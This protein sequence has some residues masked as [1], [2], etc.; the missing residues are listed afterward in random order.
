MKPRCVLIVGCGIAGQVL[1]C[2]L[3][4]RGMKMIAAKRAIERMVEQGEAVAAVPTVEPGLGLANELRAAGVE[5]TRIAAERVDIAA[6]RTRLGM[7]QEEFALRYN[8]KLRALQNWEQGRE[9]DAVVWSYLQAIARNP[10]DVA[11]AQEMA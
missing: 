8:L 3:A 10:E 4:K 9:P 6:L 2:A 7:T 1:A 5:P 11:K